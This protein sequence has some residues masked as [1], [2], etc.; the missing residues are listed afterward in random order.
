[1]SAHALIPFSANGF[2][3][4][5][6]ALST[7]TIAYVHDLPPSA[8][9]SSSRHTTLT[10]T[11]IRL[12]SH[13]LL[14]RAPSQ[15][16]MW[17]GCKARVQRIGHRHPCACTNWLPR[18]NRHKCHHRGAQQLPGSTCDRRQRRNRNRCQSI[19]ADNHR[20]WC[21][22]WCKC[23]GCEGCTGRCNRHWRSGSN[24]TG[25]GTSRMMAPW[26][27]A[28]RSAIEF[29]GKISRKWFCYAQWSSPFD[30]RARK[31]SHP[32][33]TEDGL[34]LLPP[35]AQL[36]GELNGCGR[37]CFS[38]TPECPHKTAHDSPPLRFSDAPLAP[39][40]PHSGDP[41]R[42]RAIGSN[43]HDRRTTL[44]ETCCRPVCPAHFSPVRG[45]VPHAK[46]LAADTH[47]ESQCVALQLSWKPELLRAE[48]LNRHSRLR[49][50]VSLSRMAQRRM[51]TLPNHSE[52][53]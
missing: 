23:R 47:H 36:W 7:R 42:F 26:E 49:T 13:R 20:T 19:G 45:H 46:H 31:P 24:C 21:S 8:L 16:T 18:C 30:K 32:M 27:G 6:R 1:M 53:P 17:R 2:F 29:G 51:D 14:G 22:H 11:A 52:C 43:R 44:D 37:K 5:R 38:T 15:R 48:L 35:T 50:M 33:T 28:Q 4:G 9:A 10:P 41:V 12:Q 40:K 39:P 3:A 34:G 25:K